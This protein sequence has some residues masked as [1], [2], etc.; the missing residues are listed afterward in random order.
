MVEFFLPPRHGRV[1]KLSTKI[2]LSIFGHVS[3][4]LKLL[5]FSPA[6][7]GRKDIIN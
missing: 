3:K 2:K 5:L 4:W 1:G 6:M 7:G